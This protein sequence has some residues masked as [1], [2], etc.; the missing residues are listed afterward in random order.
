MTRCRSRGG[1]PGRGESE[2]MVEAAFKG[3]MA[4][5]RKQLK[6]GVAVDA[7]AG[8]ETALIGRQRATRP[9]CP[10]SW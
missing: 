7:K 9:R 8:G 4:V 6:A 2:V 1:R 5:V 10:S 3:D